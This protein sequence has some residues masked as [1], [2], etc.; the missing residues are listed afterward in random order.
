MERRA[1]DRNYKF[2][3]KSKAKRGRITFLLDKKLTIRR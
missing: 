2:Y 1:N 3:E